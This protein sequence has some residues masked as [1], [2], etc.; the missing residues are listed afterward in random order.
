[1]GLAGIELKMVSSSAWSDV[2]NMLSSSLSNVD[3]VLLSLFA[4]ISDK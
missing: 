4:A 1:M 2:P 3:E